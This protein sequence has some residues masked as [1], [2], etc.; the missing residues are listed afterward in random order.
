VLSIASERLKQLGIRTKRRD[1]LLGAVSAP[2]TV[3]GSPVFHWALFALIVTLLVGNLQR[4]DG[5]MGVMVGETKVDAPESYGTINSSPWYDG[6][7]ERRSIRVDSFEP[8]F[9]SGGIDRGPTPTVSVLDGT[10]RVVKTQ[11]VYPNMPLQTGLLTIHGSDFGFA[12]TLA[13][14]NASGVE[15]GRSVQL[16]DFSDTTGDGTVPVG[17]LVI[18]D[19]AGIPEMRLAV[20]VPLDG[21]PGQFNKSMPDPPAIRVIGTSPDGATM[22][23]GVVRQ[24]E[25][26]ALPVGGSLRLVGLTWYARLS[27]V[28]DASIPFLYVGLIVAMVG[29]TIVVVARQQIVLATVVEGEAG[30]KLVASVRLWR[31]SPTSRSEIENELSLAL[32]EADEESTS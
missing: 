4:S 26:L 28:D 27:V 19:S 32:R 18:S 17:F 2:W 15:T 8:S 24:G 25:D 22:L 29:L 11:R 20:T 13:I 31:N 3:W 5:L 16:V 23:D 9:R 30:V 21:S 1:G 6:G 7:R 12:A 14:L 10:G